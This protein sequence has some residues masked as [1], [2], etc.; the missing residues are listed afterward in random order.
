MS[1]TEWRNNDTSSSIA[2][3]FIFWYRRKKANKIFKCHVGYRIRLPRR[4]RDTVEL[5][6]K[7]S[8][9]TKMASQKKP[10]RR[11]VFAHFTALLERSQT[12]TTM[13]A[14]LLV[15]PPP[16]RDIGGHRSPWRHKMNPRAAAGPASSSSWSSSSSRTPAPCAGA[17]PQMPP[18]FV[19]CVPPGG[20]ERERDV[21]R[22]CGFIDYK[23][24]KVVVGCLPIWVGRRALR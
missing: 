8:A 6:Y 21:C 14:A 22:T 20:D 9:V 4:I 19:K 18:S 13:S 1:R 15:S 2:F 7:Y 3:L 16:S 11:F 10:N 24:P 23:N 17:P 5:M 12:T